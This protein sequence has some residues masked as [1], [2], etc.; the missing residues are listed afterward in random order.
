MHPRSSPLYVPGVRS[1]HSPPHVAFP[2]SCPL[3]SFS[4]RR[5]NRWPNRLR[6]I[7]TRHPVSE[8]AGPTA[9]HGFA[10]HQAV[11]SSTKPAAATQRNLSLPAGTSA[12]SSKD[13]TP[14]HLLTRAGSVRVPHAPD[15]PVPAR[16]ASAQSLARTAQTV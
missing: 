10:L 7:A 1:R 11:A 14:L 3:A 9:L 8:T 4:C 5:K 16:E 6:Q 2:Q 15:P 12:C 13:R